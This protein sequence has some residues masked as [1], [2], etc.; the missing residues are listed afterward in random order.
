[1]EQLIEFSG[2]NP[3]SVGAFFLVLGILIFT[4]VSARLKKFVEVDAKT[5]VRLMNDGAT[6]IDL[7]PEGDFRKSHIVGARHFSL[8]GLGTKQNDV[9]KLATH[10]LIICANRPDTT[11]SAMKKLSGQGIEKLYN[12][13]GG[14]DAWTAEHFPTEKGKG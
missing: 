11:V 1:M 13:T 3:W 8:E 10:G 6:V 9:N 7:R 2:N 12:L 5:A 14:F 4:E